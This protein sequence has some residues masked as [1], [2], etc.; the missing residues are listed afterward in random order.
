MKPHPHP[1]MYVRAQEVNLGTGVMCAL[2]ASEFSVVLRMPNDINR[3]SGAIRHFA[4]HYRS[5]APTPRKRLLSF[6][7]IQARLN[8]AFPADFKNILRGSKTGV[9]VISD[10]HVEWIDLDGLPLMLRKTC[11]RIP[12]TPGNLF[13]SKAGAQNLVHL[14][15]DD[16]K[17]ILV[18]SALKPDD[19]IAGIFELAFSTF[20]KRWKGKLEIK[21]V[22]VSR[23][24]EFADA[25]NA[26]DGYIMVF[27]GHGGHQKD[28]PGK[29]FLQDVAIDVWSLLPKLKRVPPIVILSACDTHAADRNHA[30][31]VNGFLSLGVR[32][33]LGSVF[34]IDARSAA[35]FTARFLYRIADYLGP[36]IAVFRQGLRWSDVVTGMLRM[37]ILTEFLRA[38][39][40][41]GLISDDQ[42]HR[43]HIDGNLAIN[44]DREDP[45]GEVIG[46]LEALGLDP[47]MLVRELENVVANSDII[48]YLHLGR[49]ETILI[50]DPARIAEQLK[51]WEGGCHQ[52]HLARPLIEDEAPHLKTKFS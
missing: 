6:R 21:T 26:F 52:E 39:Q 35:V 48:S 33:V 42:Y 44:S 49:P 13:V 7:N 3:T 45:L 32:A 24:D 10:A 5:K 41:Q 36:A 4:E 12:V 20:E 31:T 47:K 16:L 2:A 43:V 18:I 25:I 27:D 22:A 51:A 23:E 19:P 1:L 40:A 37:Q 34:P 15:P 14:S 17:K 29:L 46:M 38:V 8:A 30:T 9:R 11:T 50:D 28:E